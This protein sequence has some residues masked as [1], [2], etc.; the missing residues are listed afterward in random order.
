MFAMWAGHAGGPGPWFLVFP[1]VW[2]MIVG[3]VVFLLLSRRHRWAA[4]SGEAALGERYAR[5]EISEE[6]FRK[7]QS[8]LRQRSR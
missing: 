2:L 7:R 8:V 5:G 4:R 6:E 3:G 1:L